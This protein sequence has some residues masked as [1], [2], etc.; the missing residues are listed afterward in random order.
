MTQK[1]VTQSFFRQKFVSVLTHR[2]LGATGMGGVLIMAPR[3]AAGVLGEQ[4][5]VDEPQGRGGLCLVGQPLVRVD[6]CSGA[7]DGGVRGSA[8]RRRAIG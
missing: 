4:P 8:Q 6:L 5:G 7:R 1:T 3:R 2:S